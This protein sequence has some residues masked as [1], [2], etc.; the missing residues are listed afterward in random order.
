M[1][2]NP[3]D[4]YVTANSWGTL[5]DVIAPNPRGMDPHFVRAQ[6]AFERYSA[7][8]GGDI[9]DAIKRCKDHLERFLSKAQ[10]IIESEAGEQPGRLGRLKPFKYGQSELTFQVF[11]YKEQDTVS[12]REDRFADILTQYD[13]FRETMRF[14]DKRANEGNL[15]PF[16]NSFLFIQKPLQQAAEALDPALE[17]TNVERTTVFGEKPD[18]HYVHIAGDEPN[19]EVEPG[20][21]CRILKPGYQSEGREIQEGV[22]IIAARAS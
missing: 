12:L 16:K 11:N 3:R 6:E 10:E 19:D 21:V 15:G 13:L 17:K 5:V 20:T 14:M 4:I 1:G 8:I 9:G 18:P 2:S 22:V 7:T